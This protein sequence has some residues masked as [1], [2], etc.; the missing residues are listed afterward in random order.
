MKMKKIIA[1]MIASALAVSA[2]AAVASAEDLMTKTGNTESSAN[3]DVSFEGLTDEQIQSITK[4]EAEVSV[5][6]TMVNGCIG[7]NKAGEG[8]TSVNQDLEEEA[9]PIDG[10]WTLE[11]AAGD[12][13]AL[14]EDGN[15]APFAQIQFWWVQPNYDEDGN[16]GDPGVAT[17]KSVTL[18]DASGNVVTAGGADATPA[19][20]NSGDNNVSGDTTQTTDDKNSPDT[21]V[22]GVAVVAGIAIVAAGAVVV[23]KKR[24]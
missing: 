18:Y 5:T 15:I 17:L 24:K 11:V 14:D 22:E 10:K 3:Y 21:G 1:G 8:W 9:G 6:T 13:A 7:Y 16:E 20:D 12:F 4:I 2:M 19:P 23:A